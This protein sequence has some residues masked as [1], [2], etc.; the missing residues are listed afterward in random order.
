MSAFNVALQL[1][2]SHVLPVTMLAGGVA[3]PALTVLLLQ[4]QVVLHMV[5]EPARK[6]QHTWHSDMWSNT[7]ESQ[8]FN[9]YDLIS[10]HPGEPHSCKQQTQGIQFNYIVYYLS[11]PN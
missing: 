3:F 2:R 7:G 1:E 5:H 9:M 8:E 10:D 6:G 4:L 11:T